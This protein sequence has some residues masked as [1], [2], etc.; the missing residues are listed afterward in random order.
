MPGIVHRNPYASRTALIEIRIATEL[1]ARS[2]LMLLVMDHVFVVVHRI[3]IADGVPRSSE[4]RGPYAKGSAIRGEVGSAET[5]FD[6][7]IEIVGVDVTVEVVAP[8][9]WVGI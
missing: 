8:N 2:R 1:R 3:G 4:R 9:H 5:D 6:G 7:V